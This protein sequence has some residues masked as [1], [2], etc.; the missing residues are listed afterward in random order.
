MSLSLDKKIE[1]V[2]FWKGEPVSKNK[3]ADHLK[4]SKKEIDEAIEDLRASLNDRGIQLVELEGKIVLA[5]HPD[6]SGLIEDLKKDEL[7]KDLSKAA[8]ETLSI[9]LYRSPIRRSE[10]DYI[11]GVNSQFI[12][13]NLLMRGLVDR[14][15]DPNDERSHIYVPS[16]DLMHFLGINDISDLPEF[17]DVNDQIKEFE[18][19][20]IK[21]SEDT[22]KESDQEA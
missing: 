15:K 17:E 1:A 10:I 22:E 11:R 5:T 13:R 2:L 9:V 3:L 7:S 4:V 12:L 20:K 8:L 18:E 19:Q 14:R 16:L 21:M 6:T